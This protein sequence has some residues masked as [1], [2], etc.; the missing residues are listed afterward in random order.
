MLEYNLTSMFQQLLPK[1]IIPY[2][3]KYYP[4]NLI[5]YMSN[6]SKKDNNQEV[7]C[8]NT[9]EKD[10]FQPSNETEEVIH[11]LKEAA[12]FKDANNTDWMTTPYPKG[13]QINVKKDTVPKINPKDTSVIL[14][15]GQGIIKVG[16]V[17]KYLGNKNAM[18]LFK[19]ANE[20]VNF[21]LLKLCLDGPQEKLNKTQFNQVATVI[22]S[23]AALEIIREEKPKVFESCV[24]TAG[25]S[26][27]EITALILAGVINF[28]DGI[29]LAWTRGRAMQ[30]A[31][32]II[33]QGML[34]VSDI[35]KSQVVKACKEAEEWAMN[36]GVQNPVCK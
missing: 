22:S 26:I 3:P 31:S 11:L 10:S 25:Y 17:K 21:N 35:S 4:L 29:R 30:Y 16:M 8:T 9:F 33:P 27:G 2:V 12:T 1:R 19:T 14:F 7:P 23:L 13:T 6:D 34:S 20:I 32:D 24:A 18:E 15:P 36:V 5:K 28:E